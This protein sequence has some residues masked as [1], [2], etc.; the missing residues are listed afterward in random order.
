[1]EPRPAHNAAGAG[2]N[3]RDGALAVPA[4]GSRRRARMLVLTAGT[5]LALAFGAVAGTP[6]APATA[7]VAAR[8]VAVHVSP[9]FDPCPC[10]NPVC[11]SMCLQSM[12]SGGPAAM[13]HRQVHP[14]PASACTDPN[15]VKG[16]PPAASAMECTDPKCVSGTPPAAAPRPGSRV[17]GRTGH[18]GPPAWTAGGAGTAA[19]VASAR[20]GTAI[21][22]PP[23]TVTDP[24]KGG[25]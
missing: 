15:C 20:T 9:R 5:G 23:P 1:M 3:R 4:A 2:G 22:C 6:A 25:C 7:A 19:S 18:G 12:A 17:I 8:T 21:N 11:R 13:N 16:V 14:V 24:G 10:D